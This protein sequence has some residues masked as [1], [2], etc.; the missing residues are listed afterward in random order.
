MIKKMKNLKVSCFKNDAILKQIA[1]KRT[2]SFK[3]LLTHNFTKIE[4]EFLIQERLLMISMIL[5]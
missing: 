4:S 3:G 2:K 5:S 1:N